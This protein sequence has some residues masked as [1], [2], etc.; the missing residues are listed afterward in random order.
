MFADRVRALG[1]ALIATAALSGIAL[2]QSPEKRA[3]SLNDEGKGLMFATPP[4][5][6]QAAV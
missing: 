2:A 1:V 5:Y 4:N 3:A 6:E